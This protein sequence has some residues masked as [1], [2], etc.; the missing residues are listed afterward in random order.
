MRVET[1]SV[2]ADLQ[3]G[4]HDDEAGYLADAVRLTAGATA[5]AATL[6]AFAVAGGL[7]VVLS[8]G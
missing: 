3:T 8:W 4:L 5:F 2:G 6:L 1:A 7:T